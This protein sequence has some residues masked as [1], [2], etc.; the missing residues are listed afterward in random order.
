VLAGVD[1]DVA[2]SCRGGRWIGSTTGERRRLVI[3]NPTV[4]RFRYPWRAIVPGEPHTVVLVWAP[5]ATI[6]GNLYEVVMFD[7]ATLTDPVADVV[8]VG[9]YTDEGSGRVVFTA[10]IPIDLDTTRLYDL[11]VRET[12]PV[13][14]T[15]IAGYV[16]FA[17][18]VV[19]AM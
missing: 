5:P 6:A 1:V 17:P 3:V 16:T 8:Y 14:S 9:D 2:S 11:R 19:G 13:V 10:E 12:A 7:A 4:D 18:T 15:L